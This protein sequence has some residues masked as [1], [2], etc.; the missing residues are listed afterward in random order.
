MDATTMTRVGWVLG[1]LPS[2]ML[3]FSAVMKLTGPPGLADG[4]AHLGLPLRLAIPL[5]ILEV[6]CTVVYLVPR[7]AVL[8]AILLAGYLG[9]AIVMHLRV[10]DP[11]WVQA[12]L[13]VALWGGLYL[14]EPRLR[15]LI[16]LRS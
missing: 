7:T 5:G 1:G 9:G 16:P 3:L 10:G 6:V 13:G 8:G 14:R 4:F 2:L 12:L 11:F 15:A